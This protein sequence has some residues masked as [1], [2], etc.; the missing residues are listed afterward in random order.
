ML[1]VGSFTTSLVIGYAVFLY[2]WLQKYRKYR[3]SVN[4]LLK[5]PTLNINEIFALF[6]NE[7]VGKKKYVIVKGKQAS[8]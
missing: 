4:K 2:K 5:T 8:I 1:I 6:Q 3:N 7:P